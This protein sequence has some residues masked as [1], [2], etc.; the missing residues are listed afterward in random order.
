MNLKHLDDCIDN[1]EAMIQSFMRDPEFAEYLLR[2]I[3]A[4][5][6]F[7]EIREFKGLIDEAKARMREMEF[8]AVEA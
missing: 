4:D 6:D 5:G 1:D 8:E 7:N 3:I 2:E